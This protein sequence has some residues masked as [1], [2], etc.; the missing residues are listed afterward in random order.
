[1]KHLARVLPLLL[2]L[3]TL[4][5][6]T[7][8]RAQ[9]QDPAPIGVYVS[10]PCVMD[11]PETAIE[12]R[13]IVCGY[14]NVPDYHDRP[15]ANTIRLPVAIL[16]STSLA[17]APDP[18]FMAQGGPGGSTLSYF[19]SVLAGS[20]VGR[21]F[22]AERDIVLIE[23]RGT[24]Y[25]EPNLFCEE[26]DALAY[27]TL[28]RQIDAASYDDLTVAALDACHTRLTDAGIDLS[29]YNS[30]QNAHDMNTARQALGY[31]TINFYG[32]SY[33]TMLVQHYMRLYPDTLRAVVVDAVVP[34]DHNFLVHYPANA[35]RAFDL[36]FDR[37]AADVVCPHMYPKLEEVFYGL[38][39][40]LN[41]QPAAFAVYD[42][43]TD[44][45]YDALFDGDDL[46]SLIFNILYIT[47]FI[48]YAPRLI[49]DAH[50]GDW[51]TIA[52]LHGYYTFN[53]SLSR[54]M[55]YSVLCAEDADFALDEVPL[56]GVRPE[57][58]AHF[59]LTRFDPACAVWE[60]EAL[61]AAVVDAPVYSDVPTLVLS[62]EFDPI[63]PPINGKIMA[64]TLTNAYVLTFPAVG[65]GAYDTPCGSAVMQAFLHDPTTP[66]DAS[67]INAMQLVFSSPDY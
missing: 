28:F 36:L 48:P 7:A 2:L 23:Q 5:P 62:G 65:H 46:M 43:N 55:Y 33:G 67:C 58:A 10:T 42:R 54:G 35:Q 22:L 38:V 16:P 63:T 13:D 57:V 44:T 19:V 59:R 25:A 37:C 26:L 61:D 8:P 50:R 12:G 66:P 4:W 60:V 47:E 6:P 14:I 51:E 29:A 40:S 56:A 30:L 17:P 53:F 3:L 20:E 11:L 1:M 24:R 49:W 45:Y 64:Q 18:L 21:D 27:D 41:E 34:L 52:Y 39:A 9:A 31:D 32:V 15:S